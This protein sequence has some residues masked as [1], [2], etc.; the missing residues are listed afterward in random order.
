MP[1]ERVRVE[2]A[3]KSNNDLLPEEALTEFR[4]STGT[5]MTVSHCVGG[6]SE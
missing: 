5:L 2:R 3:S 4:R 1:K 6:M